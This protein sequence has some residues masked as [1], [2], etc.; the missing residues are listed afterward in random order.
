VKPIYKNSIK[1]SEFGS[2]GSNIEEIEEL[3]G[4]GVIKIR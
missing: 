2:S 1:N 4:E 3:L